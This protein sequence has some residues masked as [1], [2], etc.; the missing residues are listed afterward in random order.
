[1]KAAVRMIVV[2]VLA[3]AAI[4]IIKNRQSADVNNRAVILIEEG[5]FQQAADLFEQ[6]HEKDPKNLTVLKNLARCY[7]KL[8]QRSK[9][10]AVYDKILVLEPNNITAKD[11][12][13]GALIDL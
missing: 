7:D 12:D 10:R 2:I 1:M 6:V 9:A 5:Q 4:F 11:Y 8:N 13:A 3:I